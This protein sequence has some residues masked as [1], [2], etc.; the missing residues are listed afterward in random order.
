MDLLGSSLK[1]AELL[2][3]VS[4]ATG[5]V[6]S[7]QASWVHCWYKGGVPDGPYL[8]AQIPLA[9]SSGT[10]RQRAGSSRAA[11]EAHEQPKAAVNNEAAAAA[12][13]WAAA[14]AFCC[15]ACSFLNGPG[16]S[17]RDKRRQRGQV[18]WGLAGN[19][20]TCY[21]LGMAEMDLLPPSNKVLGARG[22]QKFPK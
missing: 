4:S 14:A 10:S 7:W 12:W 20:R 19:P 21:I 17:P 8:R 3:G 22:V 13:L 11:G 18:G 16:I 9:F 15:S 5:S 2:K 6:L 1:S